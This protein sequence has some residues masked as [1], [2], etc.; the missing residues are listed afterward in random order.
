[1]M[2]VLRW[3]PSHSFLSKNV[4]EGSSDTWFPSRAKIV[5]DGYLVKA[6][7]WD[8]LMPYATAMRKTF[9]KFFSNETTKE[10]R[11]GQILKD[12]LH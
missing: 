11:K 1:M 3:C 8:T 4:R 10:K 9:S 12:C 6:Y 7:S 2:K 5:Q